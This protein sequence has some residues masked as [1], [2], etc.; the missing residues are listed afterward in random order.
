MLLELLGGGLRWDGGA[1]WA[2]DDDV[3]VPVAAWSRQGD[4]LAV[5]MS[6]EVSFARGVGLPGGVWAAGEAEWLE[7]VASA[8]TFTRREQAARAGVKSCFALPVFVAGAVAGVVEMY[9]LSPQPPEP[10]LLA[11]LQ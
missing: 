3:L 6:S 4:E 8:E 10:E 5:V 9:S 2:P 11:I 1:V 7:T